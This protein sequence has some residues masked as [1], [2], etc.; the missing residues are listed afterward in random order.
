M[1]EAFTDANNS[2]PNLANNTKGESPFRKPFSVFLFLVIPIKTWIMEEVYD[3]WPDSLGCIWRAS[4]P[5]FKLS[6]LLYCLEKKTSLFSEWRCT[7]VV[8]ALVAQHPAVSPSPHA[9][10]KQQPPVFYFLHRGHIL[11]ES[12]EDL[13]EQRLGCL[14][15]HFIFKLA[16]L[17]FNVTFIFGWRCVYREMYPVTKC[18]L[19]KYLTCCYIYNRFSLFVFVGQGETFVISKVRLTGFKCIIFSFSKTK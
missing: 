5:L 8:V 1:Q 7:E 14:C 9:S 4:R 12:H 10:Y 11:Y 17:D 2:S 19:L 15:G 3:L 13:R 16:E 6:A 18:I